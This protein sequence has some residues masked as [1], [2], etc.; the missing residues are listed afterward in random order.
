MQIGATCCLM[1]R[2]VQFGGTWCSLEQLGEL[3]NLGGVWCNL[4]PSGADWCFLV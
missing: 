2:L 4:V 1:Y 3:V